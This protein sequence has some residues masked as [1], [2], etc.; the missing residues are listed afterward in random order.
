MPVMTRLVGHYPGKRIGLGVDLPPGVAF[1]WARWGRNSHYISDGQGQ[2]IREHYRS[3]SAPICAYSFSDDS[4]APRAAVAELLSYYS[5]ARS[6]QRQLKLSDVLA[7]A[8]M[9]PASCL[10]IGLQFNSF[11]CGSGRSREALTP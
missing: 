8:G 5:D 9:L 3:F 10:L 6:G 4:Y 1:N 11:R 2:P 7:H